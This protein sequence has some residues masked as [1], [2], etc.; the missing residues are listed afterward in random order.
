M[1]ERH[2]SFTNIMG[3]PLYRPVVL[4]K[5]EH[6]M[7]A[8]TRTALPSSVGSRLGTVSRMLHQIPPFLLC[9]CVA[10]CTA[11][12]VAEVCHRVIALE[13]GVYQLNTISLESG[14]I[15]SVRVVRMPDGEIQFGGVNAEPAI[16][17]R[18]SSAFQHQDEYQYRACRLG[19][20][21]ES[22]GQMNEAVEARNQGRTAEIQL[23]IGLYKAGTA[24]TNEEL[25][26]STD[27][28]VYTGLESGKE[29][30]APDGE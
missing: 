1:D 3:G 9:C 16:T 21:F 15:E 10:G 25:A 20:F 18:V 27:A 19:N 12:R 11:P 24:A 5:M 6:R 28:F 22:K 17:A 8:S 7:S 13:P 14:K 4:G 23:L 30:S 26:R 29:Y 2:P